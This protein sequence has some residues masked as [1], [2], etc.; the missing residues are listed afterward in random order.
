M[1]SSSVAGPPEGFFLAANAL[2]FAIRARERC[3]HVK[4][5]TSR[6]IARRLGGEEELLSGAAADMVLLGW[7]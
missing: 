6:M 5:V 7:E 2:S 4:V 1:T 3:V